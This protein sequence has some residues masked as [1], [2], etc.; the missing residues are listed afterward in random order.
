[1]HTQI[2]VKILTKNRF[3]SAGVQGCHDGTR[4]HPGNE[5]NMELITAPRLRWRPSSTPEPL[6]PDT[7]EAHA[8]V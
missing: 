1:M 7:L 8:P 6:H 5:C 4:E 3:I 2:K